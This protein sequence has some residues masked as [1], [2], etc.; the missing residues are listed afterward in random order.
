MNVFFF[1]APN[2]VDPAELPLTSVV[3]IGPPASP[4][5]LYARGM[6]FAISMFV[7]SALHGPKLLRIN[8]MKCCRP[9]HHTGIG[10]VCTDPD[11][12]WV[13]CSAY[14]VV[15]AEENLIR[16]LSLSALDARSCCWDM[17]TIFS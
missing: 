13:I 8:R 15:D 1:S 9:E 6:F 2:A 11:C 4:C 7:R 14:S 12:C 16:E 17:Y 5:A 3:L 10:A